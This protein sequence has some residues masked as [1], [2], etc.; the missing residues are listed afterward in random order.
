MKNIKNYVCR[1]VVSKNS[2]PEGADSD[3]V[4][5]PLPYFL[6]TQQTNLQER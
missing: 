5:A 2:A 4:T 3:G 6:K 1:L